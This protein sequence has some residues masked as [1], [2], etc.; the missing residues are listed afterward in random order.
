M[1]QEELDLEKSYSNRLLG[2]IS[3]QQLLSLRQ[4]EQ[5]FRKQIVEIIRRRQ[6]NLR[7]GEQR[8]LQEERLRRRRGN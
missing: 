1:K 8:R 2:V 3:S 5:E 6:N 4:A 7:Q